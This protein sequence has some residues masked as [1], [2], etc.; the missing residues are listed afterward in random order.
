ML[1]G[2]FILRKYFELQQKCRYRRRVWAGE[3]GRDRRVPVTGTAVVLWAVAR[4]GGDDRRDEFLYGG[5][6]GSVDG[7]AEESIDVGD[8]FECDHGG[9]PFDGRKKSPLVGR[10]LWIVGGF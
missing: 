8:G 4:G 10:A 2:F 3:G 6:E 7:V 9:S 1:K 5:V